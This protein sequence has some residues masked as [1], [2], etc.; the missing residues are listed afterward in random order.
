MKKCM[1][2]P[3][4]PGIRQLESPHV[5]SALPP[6][7]RPAPR[8]KEEPIVSRKRDPQKDVRLFAAVNA[9]LLA[10]RSRRAWWEDPIALGSLLILCPPIGIAAVWSSKSYS[11]DARWALTVMTA[12][13][14]CLVTAIGIAALALR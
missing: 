3:I 14:M 10:D 6:P 12:L 1:F 13:M 2:L 11:R 9:A 4:P 8:P 7:P 5:A